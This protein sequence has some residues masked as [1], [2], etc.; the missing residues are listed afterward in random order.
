MKKTSVKDPKEIKKLNGTIKI[1][2]E[3]Y[4]NKFTPITI[5]VEGMPAIISNNSRGGIKID[6]PI[7]IEK[8]KKI[9]KSLL[10]LPSKSKSKE[11]SGYKPKEKIELRSKYGVSNK[12]TNKNK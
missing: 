6:L 8:I 10:P 3:D 7:T 2:V 12:K 5:Y 4:R 1:D 11:I 9:K